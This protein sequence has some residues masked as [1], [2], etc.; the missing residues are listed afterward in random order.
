MAD[1]ID[2][3]SAV[4]LRQWLKGYPQADANHDGVL[5]VEEANAYYQ[6]LQREKLEKRASHRGTFQHEFTFATMSDGVKIA[7]AVGYPKDFD[8]ADRQHK[9]PA[10]LRTCGYSFVTAPGDPAEYGHRC[11]TVNA[12]IRGSGASGGQL[13]PW[14][15]RTWQDGYEI[16]ENWTVKQPW[17]NGKVGI[18]GYSWP[19]L[20]GFLTATTQPPSLKAVC[21]GGLIEHRKSKVTASR[22][23]GSNLGKLRGQVH[24]QRDLLGHFVSQ[25]PST[26]E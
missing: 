9:W 14:R 8:P 20:M 4:Q 18:H 17:S 6:K 12:S 7:L 25:R 19:G 22:P 2:G 16:I 15:P 24:D 13:S 21:V 23:H 11:V 3:A 5:S 1:P 10:I 26:D